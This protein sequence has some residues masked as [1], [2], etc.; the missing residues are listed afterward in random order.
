MSVW[1][2]CGCAVVGCGLELFM[3][4]AVAWLFRFGLVVGT[5]ALVLWLFVGFGIMTILG[6]DIAN[7]PGPTRSR[8]PEDPQCSSLIGSVAKTISVLNPGGMIEID[9]ERIRAT[10]TMGLIEP[11]SAVRIVQAKRRRCRS[12]GR[13]GSEPDIGTYLMTRAMREP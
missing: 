9:G 4:V 12:R 5:V 7:L 10:S 13:E 6:W 2:G 3:L 8:E 1:G 11:G